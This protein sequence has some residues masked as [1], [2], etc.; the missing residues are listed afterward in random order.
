[1]TYFINSGILNQEHQLTAHNAKQTT[2]ASANTFTTITG[3]EIT[4]TPHND[5]TNVIY[6]I[7]FYTQVINYQ[8]SQHIKFEYSTDSGSSWSEFDANLG[9][10]F[11]PSSSGD[12]YRDIIHLKYVVPTWSGARQLKISSAADQSSRQTEFHQVTDW[13]GSGSVTDRFCNTS[14]LVYSI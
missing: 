3:S 5:A 8:S 7:G 14:L 4:F 6:E 1:M 9:K 2:S 12:Y 10:N 11:G 13:D